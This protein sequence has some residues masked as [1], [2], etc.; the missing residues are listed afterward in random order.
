MD[1][2][3]AWHDGRRVAL[4]AG[5]MGGD[6]KNFTKRFF[7]RCGAALALA[8][9]AS[10]AFAQ[11]D[12]K[13]MLVGD[14]VMICDPVRFNNLTF[15]NPHNPAT[16]RDLERLKAGKGEGSSEVF[17]SQGLV[18]YNAKGIRTRT[19]AIQR[20][21]GDLQI[22]ISAYY[23]NANSNGLG[24]AYVFPEVKVM[25]GTQVVVPPT[26]IS[27]E[28]IQN[29]YRFDDCPTRW[30][31]VVQVSFLGRLSISY[32]RKYEESKDVTLNRAK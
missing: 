18:N 27:N 14:L 15:S 25:H 13:P 12:K 30:A 7:A 11:D 26:I 2:R 23:P 29:L 1:R 10:S 31:D 9:A 5:F 17:D 22:S 6:L 16:I 21:C 8:V 4:V 3:S 24:G 28:C 32:F 20:K 19:A